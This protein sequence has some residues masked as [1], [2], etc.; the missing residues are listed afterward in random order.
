MVNE[1]LGGGRENSGLDGERKREGECK[2]DGHRQEIVR[3]VPK[4]KR[5]PIYLLHGFSSHLRVRRVGFL[6]PYRL[7]LGL[8]LDFD[9][10]G[11][12][13]R[14]LLMCIGERHTH[15]HIRKHHTEVGMC[16]KQTVARRARTQASQRIFV[17][18]S[19]VMANTR[20]LPAHTR[21]FSFFGR[22]RP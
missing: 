15:T 21:S 8:R 2:R 22:T 20:Y 9:G 13:E 3:T 12:D 7:L 1:V 16:V 10:L 4:R 11:D 17:S 18:I 6:A 14:L 19:P 5:S